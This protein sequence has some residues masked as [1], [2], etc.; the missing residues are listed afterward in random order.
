MRKG[1]GRSMLEDVFRQIGAVLEEPV[2]VF[3]LGGGAMCFRGQK[4]A[5]KDLD[6]IFRAQNEEEHFEQA[7]QKLGFSEATKNIEREYGEM[8][9]AGIWEN[10]SGFR[11]DLFVK[12]VCGALALSEGM[13]TRSKLLAEYGGLSVHIL[14]NED[15]VLFKGITERSGD[16]EDIAAI[17]RNADIDWEIVM[18]ECTA[19]SGKR[20]WYGLLYNKLESIERKHGIAAPIR[21]RLLK[22]DREAIL[23]SAF[24]L[25]MEQGMSRKQAIAELQKLGFTKKELSVL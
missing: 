10:D 9:A 19:Q 11:F 17:I 21:M 22:L 14:S 24:K 23:K 13:V 1:F 16:E 7:L 12:I 25:R 8:K 2:E 6:L 4:A 15:V 20:Q 18:E 3:M 5:T